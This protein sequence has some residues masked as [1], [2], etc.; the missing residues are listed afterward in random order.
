M[1]TEAEERRRLFYAPCERSKPYQLFRFARARRPVGREEG[2][3]ECAGS[4][5]L[6][7]FDVEPYRSRRE[8]QSLEVAVRKLQRPSDSAE[9]GLTRQN[10]SRHF[11]PR[12]VNV[13]ERF[14][15]VRAF[16]HVSSPSPS[17]GQEQ[18]AVPL[19]GGVKRQRCTRWQRGEFG[20][21]VRHECECV[22]ME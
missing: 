3:R 15:R 2:I 20:H 17:K 6:E 19:E 5:K 22:C 1:R 14:M 7:S 21:R 12:F 10:A 4:C 9:R 16:R 8:A 13:G 11:P 18:G